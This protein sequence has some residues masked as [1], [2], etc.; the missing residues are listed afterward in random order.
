M[1]LRAV[2]FRAELKLAVSELLEDSL[3]TCSQ[4]EEALVALLGALAD[5]R[6]EGVALYPRV[7]I[8][9][10]LRVVLRLLQG[11]D[12]IQLGRGPRSVDTILRAL[13]KCAPL[14]TGG[15]GVW[16]HRTEG[17]FDYGVFREPLAPTAI[18]MR[19]TLSD[20][21]TEM[22][23]TVSDPD[24]DVLSPLSE[25]DKRPPRPLL[26]AQVAPGA[27]ELVAPGGGGIQIQLSGVRHRDMPAQ[28][29]QDRLATWFFEATPTDRIR[30]A[31][32]SFS[33]TML[34]DLLR[35]GHGALIGVLH[36]GSEIP[37]ELTNDS[38]IFADPIDFG[39][40]IGMHAQE[41]S[42]EALANLLAYEKL[43]G[44]MLNS[45][46]I[47]V[48]DTSGQVHGFNC[49]VKSDTNAV[50]PRELMGGARHRAFATLCA[51]VDEGLMRGVFL[52]SSNGTCKIY[53]DPNV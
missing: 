47:V 24:P 29:E 16:I 34:N 15:W 44:G 6:E 13:K 48:L 20:L 21:D 39:N 46:G 51:L 27:V 22:L 1:V 32:E 9:D 35:H 3:M 45:D 40:L 53:G 42:S 37:K 50:S 10:N 8:C 49:F 23:S 25:D 11:S 14:A 28:R 43:L 26:A 38:V 2:S 36:A 52:Q 31:S 33:K 30:E 41:G 18:D 7:L 17:S 4:T 12:P 19:S 5:H